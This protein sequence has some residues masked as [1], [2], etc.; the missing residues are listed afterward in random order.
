MIQV[1]YI[2]SIIS[3]AFYQKSVNLLFLPL[4]ENPG[5]SSDDGIS[6]SI[7]SGNAGSL[8]EMAKTQECGAGKR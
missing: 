4:P 1:Y 5:I 7:E 6:L 8:E 2:K 3:V